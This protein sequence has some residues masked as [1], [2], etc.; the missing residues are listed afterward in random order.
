[1]LRSG[2]FSGPQGSDVVLD[3][4]A[5]PP[6]SDLHQL[7]E[8]PGTHPLPDLREIR[9]CNEVGVVLTLPAQPVGL[10]EGIA[11]TGPW[12][13]LQSPC[14]SDTEQSGVTATRTYT[15]GQRLPGGHRPRARKAPAAVTVCRVCVSHPL[16][17][18]TPAR[19]VGSSKA[20][21]A[22][23]PDVNQSQRAPGAVWAGPGT[24]SGPPGGEALP[25]PARRC[26][27][28]CAPWG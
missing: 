26:R 24:A 7:P 17:C 19:P 22:A 15:S 5:S 9:T 27:H 21:P 25:T 3:P 10:Q 1:M 8:A 6:P 4:P 11:W 12:A 16:A 23:N 14:S 2:T 28:R 20:A 18:R 13:H